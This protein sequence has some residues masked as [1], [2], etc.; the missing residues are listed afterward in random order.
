M[1]PLCGESVCEGVAMQPKPAQQQ[2][3]AEGGGQMTAQ[4]QS[5]CDSACVSLSATPHRQLIVP[6]ELQGA[7]RK[8][9]GSLWSTTPPGILLHVMNMTAG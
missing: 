5:I 9:S 4:K 6:P 7:V 1:D 2:A 8:L 3:S